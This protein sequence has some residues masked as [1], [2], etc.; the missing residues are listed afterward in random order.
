MASVPWTKEALE[1][2]LQEDFIENFSAFRPGRRNDDMV[3][4][5]CICFALDKEWT[6]MYAKHVDNCNINENYFDNYLK[7]HYKRVKKWLNSKEIIGY[8]RGEFEIMN[9][10][11]NY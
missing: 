6:E 2:I 10:A 5:M 3:D 11:I 1:K 4:S 9:F 7:E 8:K